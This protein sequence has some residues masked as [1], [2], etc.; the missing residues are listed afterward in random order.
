MKPDTRRIAKVYNVEVV[1]NYSDG[2]F[3]LKIQ[4]ETA[5]KRDLS[6]EVKMEF[7]DVPNWMCELRSAWEKERQ[8]R[9]AKIETVT[10]H[11]PPLQRPS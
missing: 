10:A 5:K 4:G 6:V 3:T 2:T 1:R 9:L 7:N 11:L 8:A